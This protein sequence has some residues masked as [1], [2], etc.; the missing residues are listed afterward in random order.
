QKAPVA[1]G[2][3]VRWRETA[4]VGGLVGVLAPL[5][6]LHPP[7]SVA[8][9]L[10]SVPGYTVTAVRVPTADGLEL[11]GWLL[12][13]PDARALLVFCHGHKGNCGQ[14][15]HFLKVL[16]PLGFNVL[17]CDFRG[18]GESPG[19]TAAFGLHETED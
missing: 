10:P 4:V 7:H 12:S 2:W 5:G 6:A 17:A 11:H 15:A 9:R 3:A 19:H 16:R 14:V 18:H 13:Q 1:A 8:T